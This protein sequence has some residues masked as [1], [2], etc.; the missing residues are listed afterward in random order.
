M[1]M[2]ASISEPINNNLSGFSV[3]IMTRDSLDKVG[4]IDW[5]I[6]FLPSIGE[7]WEQKQ[8]MSYICVSINQPPRHMLLP[9][10]KLY[11]L[12]KETTLR[13]G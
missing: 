2:I 3:Y 10:I 5:V 4:A 11:N 9:L 8:M 13:C 1:Q 12:R 7:L 6:D